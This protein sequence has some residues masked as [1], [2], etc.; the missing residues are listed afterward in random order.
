MTAATLPPTA[1]PPSGMMPPTAWPPTRGDGMATP[2]MS[3]VGDPAYANA[4]NS[5][6]RRTQEQSSFWPFSSTPST[7]LP[8][9]K[10]KGKG[11]VQVLD[12]SE[13][14]KPLGPPSN[15]RTI[16]D[17][18]GI[19]Q[20]LKDE[21][22]NNKHIQYFDYA[23]RQWVVSHADAYLQ[24]QEFVDSMPDDG[25]ISAAYKVRNSF[26][27]YD[28]DEL[29]AYSRGVRPQAAFAAPATAQYLDRRAARKLEA[30]Q[31]IV[32]HEEIEGYVQA[33][34][35]GDANCGADQSE[36][37]EYDLGHR[38]DRLVYL[39]LSGYGLMMWPTREDYEMGKF[40][41]RGAPRAIA[42]FDMKKAFDVALQSGDHEA[43]HCPH[44]IAVQ[45]STGVVFFRVPHS[46]QDVEFW[47]Y[48][49]RG[50]IRD[51][52]WAWI[53]SRDT[54][55][56]QEKRWHA[57][58]GAA[59][60]VETCRPIGERAM[61]ILFHCYDL[62][63]DCFMRV[64]EIMMF[65]LEVE[66][67]IYHLTG[68]AECKER[69]GAIE[70]AMCTF[71]EKKA[72]SMNTERAHN[73]ADAV[74]NIFERAMIFRTNCDKDGNGKISKDE[75]MARGHEQLC[76]ALGR[77]CGSDGSIGRSEDPCSIM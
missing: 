40:G 25:M 24:T 14:K 16:W 64:G 53:K 60:Q 56:H 31:T 62:D 74:D 41:Q 54:P 29:G 58:I 28:N 70:Y 76:L 34:F 48:G 66:A 5:S 49:L 23:Q 55:H 19:E 18:V 17:P 12:P 37:T 65:I 75:F 57:A 30:T 27:P 7:N 20:V 68:M 61:A 6:F 1:W 71:S 3:H 50:V 51:F 9:G 22:H 33:H 67:A 4:M 2:H 63:Y 39:V 42:W 47:Y 36:L 13:M 21:D 32:N 43:D 72:P 59:K 8:K 44:R 52:N 38:D 77:P 35:D 15:V 11:K 10:G 73:S 45:M 69:D 46:G 26:L